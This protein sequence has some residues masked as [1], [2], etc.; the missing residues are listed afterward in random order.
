MN[1]LQRMTGAS[2]AAAAACLIVASSMSLVITRPARADGVKCY[3]ING[4]KAQSSCATAN[5]SCKGLNSCKGKG[6]IETT[7]AEACIVAGGTI[8]EG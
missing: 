3:G 8:V 2:L 4:C 6:W 5:N 1:T 7:N